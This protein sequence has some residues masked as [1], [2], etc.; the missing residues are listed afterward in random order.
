MRALK[1]HKKNNS[2]KFKRFRRKF[3]GKPL[4]IAIAAC[5]VFLTLIVI[6]LF[7]PRHEFTRVDLAL[8]TPAAQAFADNNVMNFITADGI[9]DV[10][11]NREMGAV[12]KLNIHY[13]WQS[14]PY[15][16]AF[17]QSMTASDIAAGVKIT[18]N[19]KGTWHIIGPSA[20]SFTPESDWPANQKFNVRIS[21]KLLNPD[22]RANEYGTSFKTPDVAATVESFNIYP[23]AATPKTMVAVAIISFNYPVETAKFADRV[24]LRRDGK[25]LNF[26][27]RF[28]RYHRTA[29]IVSDQ[30]NVGNRAQTI[31]L[32]I[33]RI[34]AMYGDAA[35]RK[36]TAN[37]TIES[38]DNLFKV[39]NIE[40]A[41]ADDARGNA[42]QLILIDMTA[43]AGN[44]NLSRHVDAY[45]LP[46]D[47]NKA[48]EQPHKWA[49]D[50]ITDE[51]LRHARKLTL[52]PVDFANPT[53][54]YQYALSYD[55]SDKEERFIY[56]SVRSG[57]ESA[58]GFVLKNGV[59]KVMRVPYPERTVKIAGSGALLSLSGDR[60]LGIMARG[61]AAAAY[62]N[63]YKVKAYEINHLISQTYNVFDPN[64]QFKSWSFGV[65][66]MAVVFQKKISF[67]DTSM[68]HTNYASVDLGD[69]LDR[70][71]ADKT[72]IFIVQTGPSQNAA[73]YSDKRLI[74]LTDLGIIRKKNLDE[75]STLFISNLSTGA[76]VAD[77]EISVLG[78]NGNA[79]WAGRTDTDGRAD[80]PKFSPSE[81]KN[82]KEPV[83]FV[84]RRGDD[85]SFIPYY[86]YDVRVEYSKFDIDGA[87][88]SAGLPMNA[89]VFSDRGI[90]RP[91]EDAVIA[92]IVKNKDFKSLAGVPVKMEIS[93]ARGRVVF[94]E[95]FSL[96]D[97]GMF[98]VNYAVSDAAAI[99]DYSAR[100]YS[101][102]SHNKTRDILG[103]AFFRVEEF[104]P[105]NLKI[106]ATIADATDSGWID[107]ENITAHISLRNL[108]GTPAADRRISATATLSPIEFTF[109]QYRDYTFTQNFIAGTGL[110][111]NTARRVQTFS[112]DLPN[113]K[114]DDNG[115]AV[116]PIKFD[117][118]IPSGT[119]MLTLI[120][121]GFEGGGGKSVQTAITARISDAPYL[122][123]WHANAD[124]G[125]VNRDAA[126]RIKL[127][128]LDNNGKPTAADGLTM[129]LIQRENLTSLIKDY[130]DYYKYQ[131]ISRDLVVNE[132]EFAIPAAG[133]EIDLN[134]KN[135]GT[136]FLQISDGDDKILANIEYFV[137]ADGN[138]AMTT[139]AQ[140]ELQ[141]KLSASEFMPGDD[142]AV[143]ITAPYAGTG[144]ITIER[145]RVYAYKW[146]RANTTASVQHITVPRDFEGTGYVNVS[147]VRDINSN[148][149]FTSPYAYAVAPF[150]TNTGAHRIKV[151]LSAPDVVRDNKLTVKYQT[152]RAAKLMIFGVDAG[153]LQV[154]RY[155]LPNPIAHF[156]QKSA[157]QVETFQILSLLLPEYKILREFAKTGGGDYNGIDGELS[158][159]L[160]NPFG[161]KTNRPVAFYS[162]II[163]TAADTP[164]EITVDIPEYFNGAVRV[165]AVAAT[166]TAVGAADTEVR[167]QSPIVI[168]T[169]A[170]VA[171]APGDVFDVN[172]VI[173]NL[174][175][176]SGA[177]ARAVMSADAS[178]NLMPT[179][180]RAADMNIPADEER[181]WTFGMKAAN[182]LGNADITINATIMNAAGNV[183]ARRGATAALSVRPI[184][185]FST[186]I[187]SGYLKSKSTSVKK[188]AIDMYPEFA[189]RQIIISRG[190]G[191][192]MRPLYEYLAHYD[193]PC[194]E[195]LV[196]RTLPYAIAPADVM[197]GTKYDASG[198]K[199]AETIST[200]KNRQND[201]GSFDLWGATGGARRRAS[202]AYTAYLTAYVVQFLNL[203]RDAGFTVPQN[204]QSRAIDYLRSF[205]ATRIN[206]EFDAYAHA[207]AIYVITSNGYV[208]TGY[209]DTFEEYAS[210]NIKNWESGLMGAYIATSYK[211]LKQNARAAEMM[212]K[213]KLSSASHLEYEN[214]FLSNVANDSVYAYLR[215]R[216]FDAAPTA[217]GAAIM[218]YINGGDYSSYTSAVV[219]LGLSRVA[220]TAIDTNS[221]SATV[222]GKQIKL[223]TLDGALVGEIPANASTLEIK[224]GECGRT[225][226]L[227]YTVMQQGYP[228]TIDAAVNGIEITREYYNAD[229]NRITSAR[230][231]DIITGKIF[232]R[233]RGADTIPNVVITDLTSGGIAADSISD[234]DAAFSE[235]R[236]DRILVYADVP[237]GGITITYT[238]QVIAAG[239]FQIPPIRAESMYNPALSG[240]GTV[241]KTFT[242]ANA[243]G[244]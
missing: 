6:S 22:V 99:G 163:S 31:K 76:P 109:P 44:E 87:Y 232:V 184:T 58:G 144:L 21:K 206:D 198:K 2:E 229:G 213:Y 186:D 30:I 114:T 29:I 167:V 142:I 202:D 185:T 108:F 242:V 157:L 94:E 11:N 148:D 92:G 165:F 222:D 129:R 103:T 26:S 209:I 166:R 127:I 145:D 81:Y 8:D 228:R 149:I 130:N 216:Y 240:T 88:Q 122:V 146:F 155:S 203:A 12:R 82:E 175:S 158:V 134:T 80:V 223:N 110:A 67:A 238:A 161:R 188:F 168:S 180:A 23:V 183:M 118:P 182:T 106:T 207:F 43:A 195:Q 57:I 79:I 151:S 176:E 72:G 211:I 169:A 27:V 54:V 133:T 4:I 159:P 100:L 55:V 49:N 214:E 20:I 3:F 233:S 219:M 117:R 19:I 86:A 141:I 119:Y 16:P 172:T 153:I 156:F 126:R 93:D 210:Q 138:S 125:Y 201:D 190:P 70:G 7:R 227:F 181:L 34:D 239:Q 74:I 73:D 75:S 102:N 217:P 111:Q 84:A 45:L 38:A 193:Y 235:I 136:Y 160:T 152:N 243:T 132:R 241:G 17:V 98:D 50:E 212:A 33:N 204:M 200:L 205:A 14:G 143:G 199:I 226:G 63:L 15:A 53:G 41:A 18:P 83:A 101:L 47:L 107:N 97:D 112:T 154:A 231:G 236:E 13:N 113:G 115:M 221:A 25:K 61:G 36:I 177:G 91:G 104:V 56:V 5:V 66:D 131:T 24:S 244:D 32:K 39:S 68:K 40:T 191:A 224:C 230:I 196:S 65:Y 128:A 89:F 1:K 48:E 96:T 164:G 9:P 197:L 10:N 116:M 35:T 78:R 215:G 218:S 64:M 147:F 173:S 135:G 62:V 120:A 234:D 139:D 220:A 59:S 95:I 178:N 51:V 189:T 137:A 237:R 90:Y 192:L 194:T 174:V 60:K 46:R 170:P 171:A 140:A 179:G 208:S 77:A 225:K 69:Y 162:G 124:L 85:V 37:T 105:D 52:T 187:R 150:A 42:Q 123:G 28:D 71:G 121:R